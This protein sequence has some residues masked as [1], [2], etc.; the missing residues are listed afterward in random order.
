[1]ALASWPPDV[2]HRARAGTEKMRAAR[3]AADLRHLRVA[4]R[5]VVAAVAG[6]DHEAHVS[7]GDARRLAAL[8]ERFLRRLANVGASINQRP[9]QHLHSI[10]VRADQHRFRLR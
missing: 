9:R 8:V 1:M 7:L 5:N 10:A 3:M 2:D 6:A 4:E